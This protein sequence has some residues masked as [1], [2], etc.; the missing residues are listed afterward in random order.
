[1]HLIFID[2]IKEQ[3]Q[4]IENQKK[5]IEDLKEI[6]NKLILNIKG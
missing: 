3:T 1:M 6:V 5:E 2:A 4:I